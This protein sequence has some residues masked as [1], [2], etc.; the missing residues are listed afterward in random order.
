MGNL[1]GSGDPN[2]VVF[3]RRGWSF[4]DDDSDDVYFNTGDGRNAVWTLFSSGGGGGGDFEVLGGSSDPVAAPS[5]TRAIFYRTDVVRILAWDG[6]AW[7][8]QFSE[9]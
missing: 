9:V 8:V 1:H 5:T 2:G 7:V 6:S 3:G 4:Y